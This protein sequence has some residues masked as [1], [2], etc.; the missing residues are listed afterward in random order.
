[1]AKFLLPKLLLPP[2]KAKFHVLKITSCPHP[3]RKA[4]L[5]CTKM[6]FFPSGKAKFHVPKLVL[7]PGKAKFLVARLL[8]PLGR[9]FH[10]GLLKLLLLWEV[11]VSCA[12]KILSPLGT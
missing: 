9:L 7:P 6:Y 12:K 3:H 4:K 5:P 1:M 8:L 11:C 10:V 2:G